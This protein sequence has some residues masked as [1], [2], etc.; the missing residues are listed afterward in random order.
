MGCPSAA[1]AS[2]APRLAEPD[3]DQG[4]LN[5]TQLDRLR[6]DPPY[7]PKPIPQYP[8]AQQY[9]AAERPHAQQQADAYKQWLKSRPDASQYQN[10]LRQWQQTRP[11][12]PPEFRDY[13][14][15]MMPRGGMMGPLPVR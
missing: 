1:S 10:Q 13:G 15:R 5:L 14:R 11:N 4:Q 6:I 2:A 9:P 12:M 3:F 8:A 7:D